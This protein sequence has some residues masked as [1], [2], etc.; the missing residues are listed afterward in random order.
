VACCAALKEGAAP[1]PL[2]LLDATGHAE[3]VEA[4]LPRGMRPDAVLPRPVEGTKLLFEIH[5]ILERASVGDGDAPEGGIH[6]S[7]PE[8][9]VDLGERA[10][11]GIL[12]IR[13]DGVCTSIHL[14][15]GS[16]VFAEGGA[17][18]DTLGRLLLRRGRSAKA[19]TCASSSG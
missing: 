14:N 7:L 15:R 19:S 5:E 4:S 18:H 10:E 12:E 9:L 13:S 2:V 3:T 16:P 8:I 1:P 17:L 11:T 6:L